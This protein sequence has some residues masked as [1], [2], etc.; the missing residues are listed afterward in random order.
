MP[1]YE[2]FYALDF[3]LSIVDNGNEHTVNSYA[4]AINNC[5]KE[6]QQSLSTTR[7]EL[8][9]KYRWDADR[10][11]VFDK[12]LYDEV[13]VAADAKKN[14][15][16]RLKKYLLNFCWSYSAGNARNP[17]SFFQEAI[18]VLRRVGVKASIE[19]TRSVA[20]VFENNDE[21]RNTGYL[22]IIRGICN[23]NDWAQLN[24]EEYEQLIGVA[25][26]V[27]GALDKKGVMYYN[28]VIP[29]VFELPEPTRKN[30]INAAARIV[31]GLKR[32]SRLQ[33]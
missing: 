24:K 17:L 18:P 9:V 26:A 19:T 6:T 20:D 16:E 29:R 15:A 13:V 7:E 22:S 3:L 23:N 14:D 11:A 28:D 31:S 8:R 10:I 21:L 30:V 32:N 5:T 1:R 27:H 33:F 12:L 25:T 4:N 2:V